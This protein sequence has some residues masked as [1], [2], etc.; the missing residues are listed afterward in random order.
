MGG[1]G[2]DEPNFVIEKSRGSNSVAQKRV[3]LERQ[4]K[5][6]SSLIKS[7]LVVYRILCVFFLI[8]S[9]CQVRGISFDPRL[10]LYA[11]IV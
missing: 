9:G 4:K 6:N 5:L 8:L 7:Q 2:I 3:R 1:I 10:G 11:P